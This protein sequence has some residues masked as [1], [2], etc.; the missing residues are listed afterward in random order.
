MEQAAPDWPGLVPSMLIT[1]APIF[2]I[3]VQHQG[4][5]ILVRQLKAH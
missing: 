3:L 1:H 4:A 2:R 5:P